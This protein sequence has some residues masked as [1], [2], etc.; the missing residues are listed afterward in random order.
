MWK[1]VPLA[2]IVAAVALLLVI[3]F[4]MGPSSITAPRP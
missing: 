3:V 4:F 2:L 1:W